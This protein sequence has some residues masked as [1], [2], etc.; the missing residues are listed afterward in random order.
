M[1]VE[2]I[3]IKAVLSSAGLAYRTGTELGSIMASWVRGRKAFK[4]FYDPA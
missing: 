3:S 1:G 2:I 4:F